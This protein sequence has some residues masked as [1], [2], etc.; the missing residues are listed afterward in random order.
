M[1]KKNGMES[2]VTDSVRSLKPVNRQGV[3]MKGEVF[4]LKEKK[5]KG[6]K[7]YLGL[8]IKADGA[9]EGEFFN[10]FDDNDFAG[11]IDTLGVEDAV[12]YDYVEEKGFNVLTALMKTT[13]TIGKVEGSAA[14]AE[15]SGVF[16][17]PPI[18]SNVLAHLI[19]AGKIEKPSEYDL[20]YDTVLKK[21]REKPDVP[22]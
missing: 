20:W 2:D 5:T 10:I 14:T 22:F 7:E 1:T 13:G 15:I 12:E 17:P 9:K 3:G 19:A 4:Y 18:V 21:L 11:I 16:N 6:G 8:G